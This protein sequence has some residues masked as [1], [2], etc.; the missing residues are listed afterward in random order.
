[1][2]RAL[3]CAVAAAGLTAAA[4]MALADGPSGLGRAALP[5]EIAAWD[6][7]VR[8]DGLGLPPGQGSVADGEELYITNCA[9]CHGDFGEG[10][11]RWP[12]L[13]GGDDTLTSDRPVKT[14][15]SYWP[16]LS[17]VYDYVNRAMPFGFAQSLETD[18]VYALTAYI[19]YLNY[20]VEDDFTLTQENFTQVEMPNAGAFTDDPRPDIP[21]VAEGPPC[22]ADCKP[23]VAITKRAAVLDVTPDAEGGSLE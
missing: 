3:A 16:Y 8:P 9:H 13:A 23:E 11:D 12:V 22:M 7:D 19:L 15:G 6:I 5:E 10:L 4:D 2:T 17:T 21:L 14:V 1:M 20:V 18:D